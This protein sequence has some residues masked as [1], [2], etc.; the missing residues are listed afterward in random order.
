VTVGGESPS[1]IVDIGDGI[2]EFII[3]NKDQIYWKQSFE[4]GA[5]RL[6]ERFPHNFLIQQSER[7]SIERYQEETLQTLFEQIH[8]YLP[9]SIIGASGFFETYTSLELKYFLDIQPYQLPIVH[10]IQPSN[11]DALTK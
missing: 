10:P 9:N 11:F 5:A 2:V 4:I 7:E 3:A 8:Q 1:L 6:I